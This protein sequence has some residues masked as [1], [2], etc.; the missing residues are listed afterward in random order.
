MNIIITLFLNNEQWVNI[1]RND[2]IIDY[3]EFPNF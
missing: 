3:F 2:D 1:F